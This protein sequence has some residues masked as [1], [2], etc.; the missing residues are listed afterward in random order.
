MGISRIRQISFLASLL[1][2]TSC[3]RPVN[4]NDRPVSYW[5]DTT[6]TE[7]TDPCIKATARAIMKSGL[8]YPN[9]PTYDAISTAGQPEKRIKTVDVW[10]GS[11]RFVLPGEVVSDNGMYPANHPARFWYLRGSLPNFYPAG[12]PGP[13]VNGMGAMVDVRIRCSVAPAYVATW[14]K[15]PKSNEDGIALARRHY[16]KQLR[17]DPRFPGTV[18]VSIREDLT[19]TEVLLDRYEEANGR[20]FWEATYW[21]LRSDLRSSDATVGGIGCT[22]RHDVEKRYGRI[23]WRCSSAIRLSPEAIAV[24]E[25]YVSQIQ[26][27]PEIFEQLNLLFTKTKKTFGN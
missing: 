8:P 13:A 19:M 25:I 3:S 26:H 14:G 15:G 10:V 5:A 20:R 16:E 11:T 6:Q 2:L 1:L 23:G 17:D 7:D 21:P 18:T 27:M 24:I 9:L 22:T 4:P 12:E